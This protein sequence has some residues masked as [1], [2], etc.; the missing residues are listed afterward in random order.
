ML[1]DYYYYNSVGLLLH[2]T[3]LDYYYTALGIVGRT[4]LDYNLRINIKW[5]TVW[6]NNA[7]ATAGIIYKQ[8]VN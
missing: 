1:L 6:N 7:R 4:L 5:Y 2:T 8:L 3:L